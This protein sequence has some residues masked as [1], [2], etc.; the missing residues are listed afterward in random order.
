MTPVSRVFPLLLFLCATAAARPHVVRHP[1]AVPA[2]PASVMWI[3]AHPDD[4]SVAAPLLTDWYR[5]Q[6]ARCTFLIFTR[7]EAGACLRLDACGADLA[8][9]RSA[10]AGAASQYFRADSIHL[11]LP[12]GGGATAPPWKLS[13]AVISAVA[14]F[15]DTVRPELVLTFDPR[16][17]TTCHPDH[18]AV[19]EIVLAAVNKL[20]SRPLV[21]FLETRVTITASPLSISL[22]PA[23]PDAERFDAN[24]AWQ[25]IIDDM[26]IHKSQF[27]DAFIDAIA[28]VPAA[29]RA[30]FIAPAASAFQSATAPCP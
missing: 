8:T 23:F 25:S 11:T 16:H 1:G 4:E 14:G 24:N 26:R 13:D 27:N 2:S 17:G 9:T 6:H 7:G 19:A 5:V 29:G 10:E 22:A 3:A 12:D 20:S 30:V 21:Y 28:A 15:I 18:A